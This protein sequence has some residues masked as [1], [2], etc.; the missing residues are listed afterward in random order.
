MRNGIKTPV[1]LLSCSVLVLTSAGFAQGSETSPTFQQDGSV[2]VPAFTL[3]P[4]DYVSPE[5]KQML[6]MR[7]MMPAGRPDTQLPIEESRARMENILSRPVAGML[8]AY[9]VNIEDQDIAGVSTKVFTPKNDDYKED[10]VLINLHGGAFSVCWPA[11]ANLESAPVASLGK[12]KVVSVN[13]RMAPE[14]RHPAGIEDASAVYRELLK[15]YRPE[16]IGIYG[17]SAGGALTAQLL[18]YFSENSI[19]QPGA[20]GIFGAGAVR[21]GTGDSAYISGYVDGSF[22]PP[23]DEGETRIDMTYGY[24]DGADAAGPLVSP[25]LH[26][27]RLSAFPPTLIITGTRANDLSPA[28]YTNSQLLKAGVNSRLIVGEGMFHCYIYMAQLPEARDAHQQIVN[29]FDENLR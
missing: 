11:C 19:P 21:F 26:P 2:L 27:D 25:A 5:A 13:Y 29:F 1:A 17:C 22:P 24:F 9:P 16:K 6:K 8:Q 23:V 7:A 12:Y 4:S 14:H 15:S 18:S 3:P 28:V 10:R 20:A